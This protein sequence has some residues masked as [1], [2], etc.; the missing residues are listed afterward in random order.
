VTLP[1]CSWFGKRGSGQQSAPTQKREIGNFTHP[2]NEGKGDLST[3]IRVVLFG[4]TREEM[5]TYAKK[6]TLPAWSERTLGA[7]ATNSREL[8]P[9]V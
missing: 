4:M 5:E 2:I 6:G 1:Q 9:K 3:V 7:T 8:N